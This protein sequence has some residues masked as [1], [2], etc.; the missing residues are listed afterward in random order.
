VAVTILCPNAACGKALADATD[1]YPA[2]CPHFVR[3][4]VGHSGPVSCVAFSPDGR[5]ALSGSHD[6]TLRLWDIETGS[7]VDRYAG[8][9]D[10]V[11]PVAFSPDG[12]FAISGGRDRTVRLWRLPPPAVATR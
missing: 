4:F 6:R 3:G 11:E 9:T 1:R 7:E 8:H 5:W 10:A 12:R 2:R